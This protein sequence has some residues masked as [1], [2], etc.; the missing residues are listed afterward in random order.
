MDT[1]AATSQHQDQIAGEHEI[2]YWSEK[3]HVAKDLLTDA[4]H[5]VGNKIESLERYLE[6]RQFML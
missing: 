1:S 3:L 4:M 5:A 2:Q 6:A